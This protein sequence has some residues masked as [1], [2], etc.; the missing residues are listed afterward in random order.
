MDR[1]VLDVSHPPS[2]ELLG[3]YYDEMGLEISTE[4][5]DL[6]TIDQTRYL[7]RR[8]KAIN[9]NIERHS[10]DF[11]SQPD[12]RSSP[13]ATELSPDNVEAD[14]AVLEQMQ[15][16]TVACDQDKTTG[17]EVESI[18]TTARMLRDRTNARKLDDRSNTRPKY[19]SLEKEQDIL[20]LLE[21]CTSCIDQDLSDDTPGALASKMIDDGVYLL[22]KYPASKGTDHRTE[23]GAAMDMTE[24]SGHTLQGEHEDTKA[25]GVV[26]RD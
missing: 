19:E 18:E 4:E 10:G 5:G 24:S 17:G 7:V 26:S 1:R 2:G 3:I 12:S 21:Y 9:T 11:P 22:L 25:E 8:L 6:F 23:E 14:L 13:S 15:A 16:M 20:S